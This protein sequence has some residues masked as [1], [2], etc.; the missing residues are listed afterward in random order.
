FIVLN[1]P[2]ENIF[3]MPNDAALVSS[4]KKKTLTISWKRELKENTSYSIYLNKAVK[5]VTEGNDSLM[6]LTFSTGNILD[7]LQIIVSCF[8]AFSK[9][10][11][12][13]IVVGLYDSLN[14]EKP[15]YFAKS[16]QMGL[17]AFSTLKAGNY[18]VKSFSDD[19]NDLIIQKT[20]K[21]GW[22][23]TEINI[24][25]RKNDTLKSLLSIPKN[26]DKI[27]NARILPPGLIGI[28]LPEEKQAAKIFLDSM[29]INLSAIF[30]VSGSNKDSLLISI[31]QTN[32]NP[33]KLIIEADTFNLRYSEK[34]RTTKL[35]PRYIEN[36]NGSEK[37]L[38]F[39][40]NDKIKNIDKEKIKILNAKDSSSILFDSEISF[41][42][43]RLK[44][45]KVSSNEFL[46]ELMEG[47]I[48][49]E[50]SAQN[51]PLKQTIQVKEF[52]KLLV[53]LSSNISAGII[54][55]I[56]KEKVI[57]ALSTN[58]TTSDFIFENLMPGEYS[59]RIILDEN[60]NEKWDPIDV[61]QQ[62][63]AEDVLYFNTPVKVLAN[64]E[65]ETT[66]EIKK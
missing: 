20:E 3:L 12:S 49:G 34:D 62:K 11:L 17:S 6:K 31:G 51:S 38:E 24:L 16:N 61:H 36:L 8:D 50:S 42:K 19:N 13:N 14:A 40:V 45:K 65:V 25:E 48:R 5:D 21:Q 33:L 55:L 60:K 18:F 52:G 66:L 10:K 15:R 47:A 30:P 29:E 9:Q 46:I 44:I 26:S 22:E 43:L 37:I 63:Q 4:I 39:E 53:Y 64:W 7:S 59:F 23:F 2:T 35:K 28:H 27:K 57:K 41:N 58:E 56:Q 32:S 54:E 1:K